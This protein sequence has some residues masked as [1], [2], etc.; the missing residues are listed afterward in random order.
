[1]LITLKSIV[2][3]ID[4]GG[5][6]L[7][8]DDYQVAFMNRFLL[9]FSVLAD[10]E[11]KVYE[12]LSNNEKE[13]YISNSAAIHI[14]RVSIS[15]FYNDYIQVDPV[16][17]DFTLKLIF[18]VAPQIES[19]TTKYADAFAL[20]CILHELGHWN[21]FLSCDRIVC[22][23]INNSKQAKQLFDEQQVLQKAYQTN[24]CNA[25]I[26]RKKA[27]SWV[28]KYHN[29]PSEKVADDY[30]LA[31]FCDAWNSLYPPL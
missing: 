12:A 26:L 29:M 6:K 5:V 24:S 19:D 27:E 13:T 31:R 20:F 22:N 7:I 2:R 30:A 28:Q 15:N 17:P 16:T 25:D 8:Y 23:Y 4:T 11:R 21:H 14:P 10:D 9:Y 18:S 1:M 3:R